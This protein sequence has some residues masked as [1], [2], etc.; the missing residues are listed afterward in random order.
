MPGTHSI[1]AWLRRRRLLIRRTPARPRGRPK[2]TEKWNA[3]R[4]ARLLTL[5][6]E[7]IEI[8]RWKRPYALRVLAA[9][10]GI[11]YSSDGQV[12]VKKIEERIRLGRNLLRSRP[13]RLPAWVRPYLDPARSRLRSAKK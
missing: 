8:Q 2:G 6:A 13:E 12:E 7:A 1:A 10:E 4:Y 3:Q 9:I 11:G 5:Y